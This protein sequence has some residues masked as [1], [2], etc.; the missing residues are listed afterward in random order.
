MK[1]F[2]GSIPCL[3]AADPICNQPMHQAV[4]T[5]DPFQHEL[6]SKTR[7]NLG[8]LFLIRIKQLLRV[9]KTRKVYKVLVGNLQWTLALK[10]WVRMGLKSWSRAWKCKHATETA[11]ST[12]CRTFLTR[13]TTNRLLTGRSL[14]HCVKLLEKLI[15][16][17]YSGRPFPVSSFQVQMGSYN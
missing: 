9:A 1:Y 11:G 7:W 6:S 2:R 5:A 10:I 13:E 14:I 12:D 15:R 17:T 16:K 3:R 8:A 4:I